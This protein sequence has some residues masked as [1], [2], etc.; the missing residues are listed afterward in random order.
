MTPIATAIDGVGNVWIADAGFNGSECRVAEFS[1]TGAPIT[2][3]NGYA[4]GNVNEVTAIAVDGSGNVWIADG[5]ALYD[6]RVNAVTELIGAATPVI[7][8]IVLDF[9]IHPAQNG[10]SRLGTHP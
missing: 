3:P 1:N 4:G 6:D 10:S 5:S 2:G 8:P 7:T 9:R